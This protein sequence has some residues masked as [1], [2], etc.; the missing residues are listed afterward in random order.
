M[1]FCISWRTV[2]RRSSS[3]TPA[4]RMMREIRA[5]ASKCLENA[6]DPK[7]PRH[8]ELPVWRDLAAAPPLYSGCFGMGSA[9]F[10]TAPPVRY[11]YRG[12][13]EVSHL[14]NFSF[15]IGMGAYVVQ[16]VR[17]SWEAFWVLLPL[18]L[19]M[20]AM[21]TINEIPDER[22]DAA[23]GKKTLVVRLGA[24]KAV[25]LYGFA[26]ASAFLVILLAPLFA[27]ASPWICL[28]GLTLPWAVRAFR[29]L[30]R[31]FSDPVRL[32]P[33]NLLTIRVHHLTGILL[34]MA[35]LI[36][37]M[38][39]QRDLQPAW[40][41][42]LLLAAFYLPAAVHVFLANSAIRPAP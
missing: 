13:G 22:D 24:R 5:T 21:I 11:G 32:A 23:A 14:L 33:A 3:R 34:I 18:G 12:L 39:N 31:Q 20:F 35:Y 1:T 38:Q 17:C 19:M 4:P 2:Q 7:H 26:M 28:A 30:I 29:I 37:G 40:V 41:A 25:W 9:F 16:A 27:M 10:Y 15:T 36:Q 42:V 6:L 8:P